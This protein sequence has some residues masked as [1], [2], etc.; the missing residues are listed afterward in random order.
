LHLATLEGKLG[1]V[2]ALIALKAPLKTSVG[3]SELSVMHLAA[4][5]GYPDL[6]AFFHA[7]GLP[8]DQADKEGMTPL[9]HAAQ[10]GQKGC[11]EF[12]IK[13]NAIVNR[14]SKREQTPLH[15]AVKGGHIEIVALLLKHKA[16]VNPAS[17]FFGG[18]PLQI[19]N[20]HEEPEIADLLRRHGAK[21]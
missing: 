7:K 20:S 4:R 5:A 9:H 2:K 1:V 16:D 15:L 12:L 3:D 18:T 19:A 6:L 17:S 13:K 14:G 21:K 11:V 8:I 10:L